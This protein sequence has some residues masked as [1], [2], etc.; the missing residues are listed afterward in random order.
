MAAILK[1]GFLYICGA[2]LESL[3]TAD[4]ERDAAGHVDNE[5]DVDTNEYAVDVVTVVDIAKESACCA[6]G[7]RRSW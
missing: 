3:A 1:M 5:V 7:R 6:V 2:K 4:R